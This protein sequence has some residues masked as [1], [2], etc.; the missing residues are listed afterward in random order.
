VWPFRRKPLLEPEMTDWMF[1]Q[2]EWLLTA[3]HHRASFANAQFWPLSAKVFSDGGLRGH[4][5]AKHLLAQVLRYAGA[6]SLPI[7]LIASH[8]SKRYSAIGTG[9]QIA[10]RPTAAGTYRRRWDA[11]VISYDATLLDA[12][13]DLIAVLAHEVSHAILDFGAER[14]PPSDSDFNEMRTDLTAAFLGFGF[15]L[16]QFRTERPIT[17]LEIA[18]A[19]KTLFIYYMNLR[20]ICFAAALFAAVREVEPALLMRQA[21]G[22]A[23][24]YFR[25]AFVGLAQETDRVGALRSAAKKLT[26]NRA[27]ADCDREK[28]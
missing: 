3:H 6:T 28:E 18:H 2:V 14:P 9:P 25:R 11:I 21:P 19:W 20:E 5:L 26:M 10:P 22:A 1:E 8:E 23:A 7:E 4:A 13:P 15:Y 12:P 24:P 16:A 27:T 17:S